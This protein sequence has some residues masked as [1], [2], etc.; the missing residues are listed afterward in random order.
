MY[1]QTEATARMAYLPPELAAAHP[2]RVGVP[3]PGGTFE[4]RPLSD[5]PATPGVGEIVYR[6]P[7]VMMGY[8]ESVRD[9]E[10]GAELT[11]LAT[12][13][14]GRIDEHG[15]LE[16]VGRRS[17]MAKLFGLRVDLARIEQQLAARG[18]T[19]ACAS[20]DARLVVA[21][22]SRADGVRELVAEIASLPPRSVDV[23]VYARIPRLASGKPDYQTILAG[24]D[25]APEPERRHDTIDSI[26][27]E[28]LGRGGF[29]GDDTF[30]S[31]GGDSFSYVEVSIRIEQALG[32]IPDAWHVI[33]LR[34][35]RAL[36]PRAR[37]RWLARVESNVVLRAFAIVAIVCTHMRVARIPAGAHIL[38][39]VAG[40]NYARFQL[41]RMQI[42]EGRR[43]TM[44][45]LK[46]IGRI[47]GV[48]VAWVAAQ[49]LVFG[50]HGV[51]TLLLVNGY[52]GGPE[53]VDG[54]WRYWFFEAIVQIMLVLFVIFRFA[55]VRRFERRHPF[56]LPLLL[57][58]P[59]AALRFQ[60]VHLVDRDYNYVY[61]PDTV[62]WCFLLGWAAARA[63]SWRERA[64]VSALAIVFAAQFFDFVG[65]EVRLVVALLL[66]AW[67]P[68]LPVPRVIA[69]PLG[70]LASASMWIFMTHWLIWPELTP[71][72]PRWLAMAG[73][74]AGGV[75]VW[76]ACRSAWSVLRVLKPEPAL[77]AQVAVRDRGVS[78]RHHLD[79]RVVL[80][81]EREVAADTA[82]RTHGVGL[83]LA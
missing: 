13:D 51:A 70:W 57:L 59:A 56:L 60:A 49:M 4:I 61:R 74:L 21:V 39:A 11:E 77:D 2:D 63:S 42:F 31:L 44:E 73:T 48:T 35:L 38:L 23:A 64:V 5:Q 36:R 83:G 12:G 25:D 43:R 37:V 9:L 41:S 28:V 53:H 69:Q 7:N 80:D 33:P 3:V 46:P 58:V 1:G 66:L 40:F 54:R 62:V 24:G 10:R 19:A 29:A 55:G 65:R 78:R 81:S 26:Y 76:A 34:E 68:T 72:M 45:A 27:Q 52:A 67:V 79:D 22:E 18:V 17:R 82:V 47:A 14:L 50:G 71:H 32:Y 6:G 20:D 75:L 8:A 16:I 15:L 30:A